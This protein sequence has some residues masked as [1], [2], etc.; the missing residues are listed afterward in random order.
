MVLCAGREQAEGMDQTPDEPVAADTAATPPAP[1]GST[2]PGDGPRRTRDEVLDFGRLRRTTV[3]AKAGGVAGG[4]ARHFD[5][6]PVI[7]RVLFVVSAFFG[8]GIFAYAALWLLL[9]ADNSDS[10]PIGLEDSTRSIVVMIIGALTLVG[11]VGVFGGGPDFGG[12]VF[13][14]AIA[15]GVVIFLNSREK[16]QTSTLSAGYGS[17]TDPAMAYAGPEARAALAAD[18]GTPMAP[19]PGQIPPGGY[20]P[21]PPGY[22]PPPPRVPNPRKRGPLLF[23]F[24]SALLLLVLGLLGVADVGGLDVPESAYPALAVAIIG[25]MLIV[26]AWYG[27]A[28]GLIALGLV[29]CI[30]LAASTAAENFEGEKLADPINAD[31]V[32]EN[33][34]LAMGQLT[35][36]LSNVA[37]QDALAGREIN[38]KGGA[39]H[40]VVILPSEV[41]SRVNAVVEGP[42]NISIGGEDFGGVENSQ[43]WF[44]D[45]PGTGTVTINA[46][47][48]VGEIEVRTS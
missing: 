23:G 35:V 22:R 45:T 9:P 46:T 20:A 48:G 28:G 43:T 15:I 17:P 24:T 37:D 34:K 42:G 30:G 2:A 47:L 4:L 1:E 11:L 27:R 31:L 44:H 13:F 5:I 36:D 33:Y 12:L 16:K 21:P 39:G 26:G 19:T 6:D 3:D 7:V 18:G 38:I 40:I 14:G 41:D 8:V 10:A 29:A 32:M 25:V